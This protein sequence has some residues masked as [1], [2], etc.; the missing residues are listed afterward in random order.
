[1]I[2]LNHYQVSHKINRLAFDILENSMDNNEIVLIGINN[3]GYRFAQLLHTALT[4]HSD[5]KFYLHRLKL[6]PSNPLDGDIT[7]DVSTDF[8]VNKKVI[9]MDDV[10]N[11][12][13]TGF[14][15]FKALMGVLLSELEVAVLVDRKHK[16]FPVKVDYVG[17][18][19]ATTIQEHIKAHLSD[20]AN[21]YVELT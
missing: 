18:S 21:M 4:S 16:K 15:G 7:L 3:N 10:A 11:T 13:R 6:S 19:L 2:V 1:M 17:L 12:G 14:Y 5:K 9:V 8:L 20:A